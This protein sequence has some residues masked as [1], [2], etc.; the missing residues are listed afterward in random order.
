MS[1]ALLLQQGPAWFLDLPPGFL[2]ETDASAGLQLAETAYEGAEQCA[3]NFLW[4][5][6]S[7]SQTG[8]FGAYG[9]SLGGDGNGGNGGKRLEDITKQE[10]AKMSRRELQYRTQ[11]IADRLPQ[12]AAAAGGYTLYTELNN[13]PFERGIGSTICF[14]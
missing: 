14:F 2:A 3:A 9:G 4:S 13:A 6:W 10:Y 12:I 8:V 5:Y 11:A 1:L 7:S